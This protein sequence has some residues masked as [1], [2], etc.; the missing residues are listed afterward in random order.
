VGFDLEAQ[1]EIGA[2][3]VAVGGVELLADWRPA[4][5]E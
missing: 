2:G 5:A 1:G 3:V 4:A